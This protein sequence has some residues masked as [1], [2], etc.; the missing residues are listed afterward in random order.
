MKWLMYASP[1]FFTRPCSLSIALTVH[2][3]FADAR[4]CEWERERNHSSKSRP[5]RNRINFHGNTLFFLLVVAC[6]LYVRFPQRCFRSVAISVENIESQCQRDVLVR[7]R[8]PSFCLTHT[9]LCMS[10]FGLWKER[11]WKS[12][13]AWGWTHFFFWD[14][15]SFF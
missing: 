15:L 10:L 1:T 7:I 9:R 12:R 13:K 4:C 3:F 11:R 5:S 6:Y 8:H 2:L 14:D